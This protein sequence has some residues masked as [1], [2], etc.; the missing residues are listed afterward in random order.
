MEKL[1]RVGEEIDDTLNIGDII[2]IHSGVFI[3]IKEIKR[4]IIEELGAIKKTSLSV[5]SEI[6][7][8]VANR[9]S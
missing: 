3:K 7:A 6:I 1:Y 2:E 9:K 5:K 8:N 4:R